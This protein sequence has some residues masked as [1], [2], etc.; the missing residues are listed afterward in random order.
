MGVGSLRTIKLIVGG[1]LPIWGQL[2]TSLSS[3]AAHCPKL[4]FKSTAQAGRGEDAGCES[5]GTAPMDDDEVHSHVTYASHL[6]MD[7]AF[8]ARMRMARGCSEG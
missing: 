1:A 3:L 6:D 2:A 5:L 7:A 4:A 8:C